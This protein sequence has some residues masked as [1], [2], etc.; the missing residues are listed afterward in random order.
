MTPTEV[1][2]LFAEFDAPWWVA[3]GYAIELAIGRP[4]RPHADIDILVL[5]R[6]QLAVQRLLA[7]WEWWAADPPGVLRPWTAG[8]VLP[9]AIHD[10]WCRPA[11]EESWRLQVMLDA[12]SGADWV[13]RRNPRL[14]RPIAELGHTTED[15]IPYLA[16]EIQLSYKA[17]RP[18]PKDEQD[19]TEV[20]PVLTAE[21]QRWLYAA[22][23]DTYGDHPW[24]D[25]L[26]LGRSR[27]ESE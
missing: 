5:R 10:I 20:L 17:A 8:E 23:T 14:R 4:V 18:R 15:G 16:P 11:A 27:P 2:E 1:A 9:P 19:F 25:R 26:T 3:G 13:S 7:G 12:S 21:R 24:R 6:D 22:L